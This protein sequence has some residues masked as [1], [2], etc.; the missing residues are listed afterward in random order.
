MNHTE[1]ESTILASMLTSSRTAVL[2][3]WRR[4]SV[5]LVVFGLLSQAGC[6]GSQRTPA[7]IIEPAYNH[8]VDPEVMTQPELIETPPVV[9]RGDVFALGPDGSLVD[10]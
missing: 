2:R 9:S 8:N 3:K 6:V 5:V 10:R 7:V 4:A 1:S